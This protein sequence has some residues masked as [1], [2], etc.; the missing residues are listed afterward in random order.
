MTVDAD[1]NTSKHGIKHD[2][3]KVR[4]DLVPW[5]AVVEIAKILTFGARKYADRNW[6]KGF[7][8]SRVYGALMRHLTLWFQGQDTDNETGR[9]HLSHAGCCIFFLLA[10]VL[11]GVGVDDRPKLP[12]DQIDAMGKY[13]IKP[14]E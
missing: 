4:M 9:S 3:D 12:Q 14:K 6:E 13:E 5:D 10:F 2:Q 7:N 11:R 8:W 1:A